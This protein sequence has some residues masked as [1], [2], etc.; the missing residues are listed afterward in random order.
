M[1]GVAAAEPVRTA[2]ADPHPG[3]HVEQWRDGVLARI[4]LVQVNLTSSE[5]GV[6]ATKQ[7]DRGIATS[8]LARRLNAQVA[9][10]GDGFHAAGFSPLGLAIGNGVAWSATADDAT[11]ALVHFSRVAERTAAVIEPPELVAAASDL[12]SGTQAVSG[13]PLLVRSGAVESAFDCSDPVTLACTRAPRSAA[14]LSADRNTLWIVVVD[15]W[16]QSSAGMTDAE[17]AAFLVARGA[18]MAVALDSGGSSTLVLDGAL[19]SSPSD[20]VERPVANHLAIKY[21]ALPAGR[22]LGVICESSITNC[23]RLSGVTVT[24]DDGRMQVTGSDAFYEFAPITPRLACVTAAKPGFRTKTQCKQVDVNQVPGTYNSMVLERGTDP[25]D[26]GV[27][28]ASIP[29]DSTDVIDAAPDPE[30]G[31]AGPATGDGGGGGGGCCEAAP[32]RDGG[33]GPAVLVVGVAWLMARRRGTT[34][35]PP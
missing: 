8:E 34:P 15:G 10:N 16:Q 9:V 6:Y 25:P 24:L 27:A 11:S 18:D 20:G 22:M 29:R 13:H 28:D 17:L 19:A 35:G 1:H 5:I 26:A 32:H 14:A 30:G 21:G 3:I 12:P 31:D 2:V 7:E 4:H 33:P 23:M